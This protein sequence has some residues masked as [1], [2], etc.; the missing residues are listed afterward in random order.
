MPIIKGKMG[1]D[2]KVVTF[3][4]PKYYANSKSAREIDTQLKP[5]KP[6]DSEPKR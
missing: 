2:S 4:D 1:K 3:G 6:G 5:E